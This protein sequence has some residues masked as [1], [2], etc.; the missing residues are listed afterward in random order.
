MDVVLS[1]ALGVIWLIDARKSFKMLSWTLG[2]VVENN[3]GV[4]K[5]GIQNNYYIACYFAY[6]IMTAIF[7]NIISECFWSVHSWVYAVAL[8]IVTS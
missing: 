6:V 7:Q 2:H 4:R 8:N 1:I 5:T 3:G